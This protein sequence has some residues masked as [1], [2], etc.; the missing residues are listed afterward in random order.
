MSSE[1]F[2]ESA[3]RPLV[4]VVGGSG[5]VG[6][7]VL[8]LMTDAFR[9]RLFDRTPPSAA[10]AP[11]IA[12]FVPGDVTDGDALRDAAQGAELLL[13]MAM[14]RGPEG[15]PVNH[16]ASA[17]DVNVKGVHLALDAAVRAGLRRA[18]YTSSLSVMDRPEGIM[19]G[20]TD[21]EDIP[22]I[23]N[24]VYGHTKWLG[25]ETCRFVH[26]TKHLPILAL[27]LFLPVSREEWLAK[28]D[29]A[30]TDCRT[31][32]PDLARALTAA[33]RSP[34]PDFEVIHVTG[35]TTGRAYRHEKAR[36]LLGWQPEE[37]RQ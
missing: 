17:Y 35:D 22:P 1:T 12:A 7:L 37:G 10:L 28:H 6:G 24:S 8:P 32:A 25:E 23:P 31:S 21:R 15:T 20:A 26:R 14:G 11:H 27:R 2:P 9:F 5:H 4:L 3:P 16:L 18:V 30:Q 29:P 33:L 34:H 36:R 19:S 13:Y